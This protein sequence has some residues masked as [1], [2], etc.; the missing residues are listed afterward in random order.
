[1]AQ[2]TIMKNLLLTLSLLM[3]NNSY[4]MASLE[5]SF[6]LEAKI[7][8]YKGDVRSFENCANYIDL[9]LSG[10]QT[11]N[12]SKLSLEVSDID[13]DK[14][15][16]T[17]KNRLSS[18]HEIKNLVATKATKSREVKIVINKEDS[19][20]KIIRKIGDSTSVCTYFRFDSI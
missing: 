8:N 16:F 20:L 14:I 3:L 4:A 11:N 19:K 13:T 7:E 18:E 5:G 17:F 6:S 10:T 2:G 12:N 9:Y 1:M 15:L